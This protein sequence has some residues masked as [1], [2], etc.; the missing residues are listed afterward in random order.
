M[1]VTDMTTKGIRH[2]RESSSRCKNQNLKQ[3]V[4]SLGQVSLYMIKGEKNV[5]E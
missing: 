5:R 2:E 4:Y 1:V 3:L